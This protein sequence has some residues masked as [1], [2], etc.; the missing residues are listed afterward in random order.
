MSRLRAC[1]SAAPRVSR[2]PEVR[3][4]NRLSAVLLEKHDGTRRRLN[5]QRFLSG[6]Q[7]VQHV[8]RRRPASPRRQHSEA[9]EVE[10]LRGRE[11]WSRWRACISRR[12]D[13]PW[14]SRRGC[15]DRGGRQSRNRLPGGNPSSCFPGLATVYDAVGPLTTALITISKSSCGLL[16]HPCPSCSR[17]SCLCSSLAEPA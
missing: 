5:R 9:Q 4:T 8:C 1:R 2:D 10:V 15:V 17:V 16:V 12:R 13:N 3:W 6:V 11:R 7:G 14:V